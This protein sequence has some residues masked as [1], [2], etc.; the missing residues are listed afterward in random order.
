MNLLNAWER[1]VQSEIN[2]AAREKGKNGGG[3]GVGMEEERLG[4]VY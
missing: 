4:F 1:N 3:G 2:W